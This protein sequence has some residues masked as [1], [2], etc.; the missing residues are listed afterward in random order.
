MIGIVTVLFNG[1]DLLDDFFA[2]MQRQKNIDFKI[3]FIDNS[4]DRKAYE[5]VE[6]L[7]RRYG[8]AIELVY[9]DA[10]LGVAKGNNIGIQR[11]LA[12]GC[13]YVLL[14]NYDIN[15][16]QD[17]A[18]HNLVVLA[19][20]RPAHLYTPKI[21][22]Y[23]RK[24]MWYAGG[25]ID[26]IRGISPHHGD[27]QDDHGQCDREGVT[28]YAPTC[29]MLIHKSVFE[30]V[31]LMDEKYFV[32]LDDTDFVARCARQGISVY[33]VPRSVVQHKVSQTT[34]GNWSAFTIK[35]TN[36]NRIYFLKKN[37]SAL[38]AAACTVYLYLFF[39]KHAGKLWPTRD[40][41]FGAINEGWRL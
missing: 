33:Y 15:I 27:G 37:K 11:A 6:E 17:D 7:N 40:L 30:H 36:K 25:H 35:Q 41:Y 23:G 29:F 31:G 32:Y 14:S 12:D 19:Q 3:Y 38:Y 21:Y 9:N 4:P 34:G 20:A 8:F 10:N 2:S 22:Y 39:V 18:I 5:R 28:D 13:E 16:D 24:V 26:Y 1:A